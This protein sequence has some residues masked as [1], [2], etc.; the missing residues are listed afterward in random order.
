MHWLFIISRQFVHSVRAPHKSS[1][2]N[3]LRTID[4]CEVTLSNDW[5]RQIAHA[6]RTFFHS[7]LKISS[8]DKQYESLHITGIL[9]INHSLFVV[10]SLSTFLFTCGNLRWRI[11]FGNDFSEFR[12][13][14]DC[15]YKGCGYDSSKSQLG[16]REEFKE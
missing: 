15:F 3:I 10:R 4:T 7:L 14:K 1:D 13:K 5:L 2:V 16:I 11:I 6:Q 12:H 8:C 9:L